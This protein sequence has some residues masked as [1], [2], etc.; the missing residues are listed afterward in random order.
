MYPFGE[1]NAFMHLEVLA[2]SE[3]HLLNRQHYFASYSY[4]VNEGIIYYTKTG[5]NSDVN[6]VQ[7]TLYF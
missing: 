1:L 6:T 2:N 5:F 7:W 4:A 3:L